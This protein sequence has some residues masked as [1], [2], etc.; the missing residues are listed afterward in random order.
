MGKGAKETTTEICKTT[1]A[2]I[3]CK[4]ETQI[5]KNRGY[6]MMPQLAFC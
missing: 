5:P 2:S 4:V 6:I 1:E 3:L